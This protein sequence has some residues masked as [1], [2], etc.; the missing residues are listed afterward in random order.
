MA[1]K[2]RGNFDPSPYL[3]L[4]E[5]KSLVWRLG[6]VEYHNQMLL[7]SLVCYPPLHAA[8]VE[9]FNVEALYLEHTLANVT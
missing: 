4:F 7:C 5:G 9:S 3:V 1:T 2:L 8:V 6:F